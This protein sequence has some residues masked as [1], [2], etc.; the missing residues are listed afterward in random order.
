MYK[1]DLN[2]GK[3]FRITIDSIGQNSMYGKT[4]NDNVQIPYTSIRTIENA[5]KSNE[6]TIGLISL[7]VAVSL[8]LSGSWIFN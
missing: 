4:R 1:F 3:E 2:N 5:E 7:I 8:L 6:K